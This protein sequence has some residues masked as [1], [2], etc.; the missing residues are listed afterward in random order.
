MPTVA[1]Q[2]PYAPVFPYAGLNQTGLNFVPKPQTT[3]AQPNYWPLIASRQFFTSPERFPIQL[4]TLKNGHRIIIEQRPS[5]IIGLRTFINTGSILENPIYSS[6]YYKNSGLPSGIAHL[7]EHSRFLKTKHFPVKNTWTQA[8][9]NLG[10][11][12]NASTSSEGIQH[13]LFFNREVLPQMLSM[14][15]ESILNPVYDPVDLAQEKRNVLNE[16]SLRTRKPL[17][18]IMNKLSELMFDRA[19]FQ[20][21]GTAQDVLRSTPADLER[22]RQMAYSPGNMVTAVVGNVNPE[23]VLSTLAPAFSSNPIPN[24]SSPL[25]QIRLTLPLHTVR[26]QSIYNADL[27]DSIVAMNFPAPPKS[28]LKERVTIHIIDELLNGSGLSLFQKQLIHQ[29]QASSVSTSYE[30]SKQTGVYAI[31]AETQPGNE[32]QALNTVL[33][34]LAQL[35]MYPVSAAKLNDIKA[36]LLQWHQDSSADVQSASMLLGD[37]VTNGTLAYELK[38]PQLLG[39][40]TP[41]DIM[42]TAQKYLRADRYAVVFGLP[43]K[44]LPNGLTPPVGMNNPTIDKQAP[45]NTG[46]TATPVLVATAGPANPVLAKPTTGNPAQ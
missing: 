15:A 26:Q 16:A 19:G 6:P 45:A 1:L 46:P 35:S 13:E 37:A 34:T 20:P 5:D 17:A 10:S 8:V 24:Q 7:D 36:C 32:K 44:L 3:V 2:M 33:N 43:M 9:D 21:L 41:L 4:V 29:G 28:S 14:H 42:Q 39:Q 11:L 31:F 12:W 18:A 38:F 40:I 30:P 22:F 23:M 27:T 25:P